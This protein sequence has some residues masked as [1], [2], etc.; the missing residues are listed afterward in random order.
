MFKKSKRIVLTGG[1]TAGHVMPHIALLPTLQ[2]EGWDVRYIGSKNGIEKKILPSEL[3]FY[4]IHTGK[5]RRYFSVQNFLDLF[6]LLLGCIEAL[7]LLLKLRPALVFSKGGFVSVP[8]V[9][10]AAFWR[11][12]IVLHESDFSPGLAN[13]L[14]LPFARRILTAFAPTAVQLG[15]KAT[16]VGIPLRPTLLTGSK[17]KARQILALPWNKPLLLFMGGSLGARSVNDMVRQSLDT[18]LPHFHILHICGNGNI[19]D[20]LKQREGYAQVEFVSDELPHFL[21]ATDLIVCRA[22]A[23]TL[24][25]IWALALPS[26]LLPLGN[27][28]SRGDQLENAKVF[29]DQGWAEVLWPSD[30]QN[31]SLFCQQIFNAFENRFAMQK[32]MQAAPPPNSIP[33]ILAAL[34]SVVT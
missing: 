15:N 9:W 14:C 32:A 11:I 31:S 5:L 17:E 29:M 3:P 20:S 21:A 6:R 22:G 19:D 18:L 34:N 30:Q 1:G 12:P 7:W 23:T 10:A 4:S 24:A 25:E 13:R 27:K 28:A 26:L 2:K 8:V 33:L 16:H